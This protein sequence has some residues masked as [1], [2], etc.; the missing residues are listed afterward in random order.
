[1]AVVIH[2]DFWAAAQAMPEKQR[3][4]FIYAVAAYGFSGEEPEGC[5]PWLP[6][7]LVIKGR[8]DLSAQASE[9]GRRMARARWGGDAAGPRGV[10]ATAS[11]PTDA[12]AH[13]RACA[14]AC[15][16]QD[17]GAD[18][19]AP[20]G[21]DAEKEKEKEKEV[22]PPKP[23][24][25]SIVGMLNRAAGTAYR[26]ES[27]KTRSLI[28]ARWREGWREEDFATV[29]E[30]L[31]AEWGAD[32]KMASY[33]RPETLF[34]SKFEG[35]VNRFRRKRP[36]AATPAPQPVN[37]EEVP[38]A[39]DLEAEARAFFGRHGYWPEGYGGGGGA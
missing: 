10:D 21:R 33:L 39:D 2:D 1:M 32:E 6:T 9:R 38:T 13:A 15:S 12:Q 18:A 20:G 11:R 3:A 30:G 4:G 14:Q 5:P 26:P 37:R 29:I 24:Y 8:I 25:E 22:K 34:G 28:D 36:A 23:P 35:Y 16:G 27:R 17:A 31:A 7:F 19:R